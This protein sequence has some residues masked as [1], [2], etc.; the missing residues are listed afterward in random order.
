MGR[1]VALMDEYQLRIDGAFSPETLPMARLAAYI[2]VLADL[3]GETSDVHFVEVR[4]GSAVPVARVEQHAIP[5][6]RMRI[7]HL[8]EGGGANDAR[9]AAAA[10]D[11][12]LREDNA[13]GQL[14]DA[15]G[16]VLLQFPGRNRIEPL[17]Y[18]PV[19]QDGVIHGQVIRVGGRDETV[20]V[21]LRDGDTVYTG[22]QATT[23]MARRLGQHLYGQTLRVHGTG[24]WLR[25]PSGT[26][27]LR[28]FRI[29]DFELLDE[30]PFNIVIAAVR[31]VDGSRWS[32]VKDPVAE[33][34]GDRHGA[35][36]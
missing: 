34:L 20:P 23:D 31:A 12:L 27:R 11:A 22:L 18:G 29:R 8:Q 19:R 2:A 26:W 13:T 36:G 17:A 21:H 6:V 3:L 7:Q 35:T 10:A 16:A 4:S 9:A 5:K 33:L 1:A 32:E 14:A 28:D 30:A 25:E 24:A 15:T